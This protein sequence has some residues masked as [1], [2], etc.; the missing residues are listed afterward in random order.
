MIILIMQNITTIKVL[1]RHILK[2]IQHMSN[3]LSEVLEQLYICSMLLYLLLY[4][5]K[6]LLNWI[7]VQRIRWQI[8]KLDAC[9]VVYILNILFTCQLEYN[10][11]KKLTNIVIVYLAIVNNN[12]TP[13][14]RKRIAQLQKIILN[15][16]VEHFYY[17]TTLSNIVSYEPFFGIS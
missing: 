1:K 8:I 16:L 4:C 5:L 2:I 3:E 7:V 15:K 6:A 12:N 17:E 9:Y 11:D 13:T 14:S 10:K